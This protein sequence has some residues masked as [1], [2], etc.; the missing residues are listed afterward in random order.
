MRDYHQTMTTQSQLLCDESK[1]RMQWSVI[2]DTIA[3][4]NAE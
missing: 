1:R 4:Q 2:V 3:F